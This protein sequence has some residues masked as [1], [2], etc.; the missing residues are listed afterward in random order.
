MWYVVAG[1]GIILWRCVMPDERLTAFTNYA[2]KISPTK[3]G[4]YEGKLIKIR[5]VGEPQ[6]VEHSVV[7]LDY[8]AVGIHVKETSG[9]GSGSP[10][11]TQ[12]YLWHTIAAIGH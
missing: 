10:S 1:L 12:F 8:D 11:E 7:M 2:H 5:F 6:H 3:A 4:D 9:P